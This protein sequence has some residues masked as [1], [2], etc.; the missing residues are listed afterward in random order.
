MA[1][2]F[3]NPFSPFPSK[4]HIG[5][6]G[7]PVQTGNHSHFWPEECKKNIDGPKN[8]WRMKNVISS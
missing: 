8:K 6:N 2:T 4:V 7:T 1:K 5:S 3:P